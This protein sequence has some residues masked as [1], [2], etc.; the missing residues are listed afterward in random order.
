[1]QVEQAPVAPPAAVVPKKFG[2]TGVAA[3]VFGKWLSYLRSRQTLTSQALPPLT[4]LL[5]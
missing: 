1:M 2:G 3:P 4:Q 5:A